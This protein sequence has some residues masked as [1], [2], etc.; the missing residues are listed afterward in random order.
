MSSQDLSILRELATEIKS[1]DSPLPLHRR[2]AVI[3]SLARSVLGLYTCTIRIGGTTVNV[4]GVPVLGSY[5][6]IVN[7]V[8]EIIRDGPQ[9]FVLGSMNN[10]H[11]GDVLRT[12]FIMSGGKATF[13]PV[14]GR[15]R[16]PDRMIVIGNGSGVHYSTL[17]YFDIAMPAVGTAVPIFPGATTRA[18]E[19]TGILLDAWDAL[20]YELPLGSN[21]SSIPGNF[22]IVRYSNGDY[23][24]PSNW[25]FIAS[26]NGDSIPHTARCG[27]GMYAMDVWHEVGTAGEP[28]FD[29]VSGWSN[30]NTTVF[31]GAA[32]RKNVYDG[33]VQLRGMVKGGALNST[34][35]TMPVGYRPERD[36]IIMPLSHN[37][38]AYVTGDFRINT[39]GQA[40]LITGGT[41]F[42]SMDGIIY[43][44]P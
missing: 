6:P 1:D 5:V 32:F 42:C 7:D 4:S 2:K 19:T 3:Q 44:V 39:G 21:Q 11:L 16:W 41:G 22:R 24:I 18:W 10:S 30:Y 8:V 13:N 31:H 35:F 37:G 26:R 38:S 27:N 12:N 17:G 15:F 33:T 20:Y 25:I 28:V 23:S 34:I 40:Y 36:V 29:P 43:P 9:L 14:T